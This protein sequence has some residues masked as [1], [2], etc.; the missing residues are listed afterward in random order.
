MK[1]QVITS[2]VIYLRNDFKLFMSQ[3]TCPSV[4]CVLNM[5]SWCLLFF[6]K[7]VP[8][9]PAIVTFSFI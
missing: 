1:C 7:D 9:F 4:A 5:M 8:E 3:C 6:L 2:Y